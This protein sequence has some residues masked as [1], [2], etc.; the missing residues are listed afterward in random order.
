MKISLFLS[1]MLES[2]WSMAMSFVIGRSSSPRAYKFISKISIDIR[3]SK[4]QLSQPIMKKDFK[5]LLLGASY[6]P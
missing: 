1:S 6:N 4:Y 5:I 2:L 3:R